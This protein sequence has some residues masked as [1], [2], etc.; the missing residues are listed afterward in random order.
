MAMK[1]DT[2]FDFDVGRERIYLQNGKDTGYDA[3]WRK[4][5]GEALSIVSPNY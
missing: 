1:D 4:D 2:K 5:N 3:L